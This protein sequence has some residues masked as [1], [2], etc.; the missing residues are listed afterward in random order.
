M[1]GFD[2]LI[3][4]CCGACS[5]CTVMIVCAVPEVF[6]VADGCVGK[7]DIG[8]IVITALCGSTSVLDPVGPEKIGDFCEDGGGVCSR[9]LSMYSC[10]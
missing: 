5:G 10:G 1:L 2:L 7:S 9:E 4:D 6:S 3:C 8:A